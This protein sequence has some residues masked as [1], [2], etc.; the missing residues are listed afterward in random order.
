MDWKETSVE[1]PKGI[2]SEEYPYISEK[3]LVHTGYD[4]HMAFYNRKEHKWFLADPY[5]LT[6]IDD[7]EIWQ[8]LPLV[9]KKQ[10]YIKFSDILSDRKKN[11]NFL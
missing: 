4:Y 5:E 6:W 1:L 11:N 10:D 7:V 2:W 3:V 8:P 9:P